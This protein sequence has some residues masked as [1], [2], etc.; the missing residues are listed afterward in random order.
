MIVDA[1]IIRDL[2]TLMCF[3]DWMQSRGGP[4]VRPLSTPMILF[5]GHLPPAGAS[6]QYKYYTA[7]LT[8]WE[9]AG[10]RTGGSAAG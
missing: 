1:E 10:R 6:E 3:L 8:P 7:N 2:P 4:V 9:D 5:I